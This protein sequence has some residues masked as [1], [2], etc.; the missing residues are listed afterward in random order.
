M[1]TEDSSYSD[2]HF[3]IVHHHHYHPQTYFTHCCV[4]GPPYIEPSTTIL[5]QSN[6]VRPVTWTTYVIELPRPWT[7]NASSINPW[8]SHS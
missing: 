2:F 7:S 6:Q 5:R 3:G 4:L 8:P 1:Q